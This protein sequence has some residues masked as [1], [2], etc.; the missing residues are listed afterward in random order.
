MS[1]TPRSVYERT[2]LRVI[3]GFSYIVYRSEIY[4]I[5]DCFVVICASIYARDF[6]Y[7]YT[8]HKSK[9]VI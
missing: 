4:V 2:N 1:I 6:V 7:S 5:M 9:A 3:C 8:D